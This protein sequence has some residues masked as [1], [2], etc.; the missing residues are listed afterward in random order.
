MEVVCKELYCLDSSSPHTYIECT[1][2]SGCIVEDHLNYMK[3]GRIDV[4]LEMHELP[5]F[6]WLPKM[7][8]S[9]YGCRFIAAGKCTTKPLSGILTSCFTTI[10]SHFKEYC[11]GIYR[12]TGVNAFW[13]INNSQQVLKILHGVNNIRTGP[14][15]GTYISQLVG[16]GRI[17]E[18]IASRNHKLTSRLLK[19]GFWY[20]K[21]CLAFKK[22]SNKHKEIFSKF[23]TSLRQHIAESICLPVCTM[24][25]LTT[26][27]TK[28]RSLGTVDMLCSAIG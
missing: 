23:K 27:V 5:R 21:L 13:I 17:C 18:D 11:D 15:Y 3:K 19:Q 26:N 6:Y 22:F 20:C 12:N 1:S 9:P 4:P 2:D 7:H 24:R 14:A 10:L 16:M 28:R 25:H 8:K